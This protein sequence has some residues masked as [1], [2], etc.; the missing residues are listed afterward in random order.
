MVACA[1]ALMA[2]LARIVASLLLARLSEI[3]VAMVPH[4]TW[5]ELMVVTVSAPMI[6]RMIT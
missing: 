6:T 3:A 5:T 1:I 2:T 4:R